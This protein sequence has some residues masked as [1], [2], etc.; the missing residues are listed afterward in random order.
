M[1][2]AI[3]KSNKG[4]DELK[5]NKN[6]FRSLKSSRTAQTKASSPETKKF[7]FSKIKRSKKELKRHTTRIHRKILNEALKDSNEIQSDCIILQSGEEKL[8]IQ[9]DFFIHLLNQPLKTYEKEQIYI[10]L[11]EAIFMN[12]FT[13]MTHVRLLNQ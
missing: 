13:D 1:V 12:V 10:V 3:V 4:F 2:N 5:K 8:R 7:S 9:S 6:D 11:N